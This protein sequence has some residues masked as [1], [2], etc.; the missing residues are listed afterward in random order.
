MFQAT[1]VLRK[2]HFRIAGQY[3]ALKS[4]LTISEPVVGELIICLAEEVIDLCCCEGRRL[5]SRVRVGFHQL[6]VFMNE[7]TARSARLEKTHR[8]LLMAPMVDMGVSCNMALAAL[9]SN[10]RSGGA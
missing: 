7:G 10:M 1:L 2:M 9:T 4:R 3:D 8:H 6:L 5:G